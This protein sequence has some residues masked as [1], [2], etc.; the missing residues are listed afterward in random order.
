MKRY[1]G[2]SAIDM[3]QEDV[4]AFRLTGTKPVLAKTLM[5][6]FPDRI[7]SFLDNDRYQLTAFLLGFGLVLFENK[8]KGL[9]QVLDGLFLGLSLADGFRQLDTSGC[10]ATRFL[11]LPETN[12]EGTL[13]HFQSAP[14]R[15]ERTYLHVAL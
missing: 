11:I 2:A 6:S 15:G 13:T 5:I 4:T 10:I 3:S 12:S 9:S 8:F 7:G 14:K 1:D